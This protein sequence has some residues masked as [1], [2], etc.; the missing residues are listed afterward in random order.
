[1]DA[2]RMKPSRLQS[3]FSRALRDQAAV[4]GKPVS[5]DAFRLDG[6]ASK[7]LLKQFQCRVCV[8]PFP[9]D[10]IEHLAFIMDSAPQKHVLSPTLANHLVEM[11]A[12]RGRKFAS[13]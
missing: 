3:Q 9:N 1:M 6:W 7:Q 8:T 2:R 13:R 12:W 5:D 4:R 11:P 10:G